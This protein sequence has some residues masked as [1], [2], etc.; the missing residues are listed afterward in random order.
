MTY[1]VE[2]SP[3][4]V[5]DIEQ[6]FL[7]M[8]ESSV[9][10]AHRWVR[11]CYEIMLTLEKFPKRCPMSPESDYMG[12]EIRQLLYKKQFRILFTVNEIPEENSGIVRIHR[13]RHGSQDRLRDPEQ[14]FDDNNE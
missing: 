2:I 10:I 3:T 6:I 14:L 4:A 7:W 12:I 11:G 5:A 8:R 13:V 1:K 9:D